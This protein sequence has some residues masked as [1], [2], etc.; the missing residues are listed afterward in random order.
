MISVGTSSLFRYSYGH[1]WAG[2][3]RSAPARGSN[4]AV[5]LQ[6]FSWQRMIEAVQAVRDRALRATAALEK[7]GIPYAVAGG[8]AVAAW[9]ARVARGV[10]ADEAQLK[11]RQGSHSSS[12]H[13]VAGPDRRLLAAAAHSRAC[14][15]APATHRRPR[16][17]TGQK[18]I[19]AAI[20]GTQLF[21]CLVDV[22]TE[23]AYI[24]MATPGFSSGRVARISVM[25]RSLCV[26]TICS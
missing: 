19:K 25:Y 20:K 12:R 18:A 7:A 14:R 23:R 10:G 4:V 21:R 5:E 13:A 8:N 6:P 15:K 1:G 9:V 16:R 11:P 26:D 2:R 3:F 22:E 24:L 17:L